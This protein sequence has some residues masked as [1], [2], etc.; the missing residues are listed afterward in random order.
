MAKWLDNL[1]G[2]L[3]YTRAKQAGRRNFAG[4]DVSR[5]TASWNP[6]NISVN[7]DLKTQLPLLRARSR[8]LALN[9]DYAI[10]FLKMVGTHV[11][12]P[13][14]FSLQVHVT[15]P[16]GRPDGLANDAIESA[17]R[18]WAKKGV[19]D[20]TGKLS[21]LDIQQ[22]VAK[23]VARD[24]E[25]LIRKVYG[26]ASGNPHGFGLQ[27]LAIDR[28]DVLR[29]EDALTRD[30][31]VIRMG[32]E[33]TKYGKPIAYHLRVTNPADGVY[34]LNNGAMYERVPADQIY[35]LFVPH[36][37]EQI[38]GIPWMHTAILRLQNL[39]G[40]EEAAV[41][42]A[43]VGASKM[44]F[45]KTDDGD[46]TAMAD[47][48]DAQGNLI[49]EADP[50]VFDVLP[51]GVDFQSFN[52]DYPTANYEPFVKSC[53]RGIA[54]GLGV[55]YNTLSNDL[56]GVNFSSIRTGV[57]EERDNWMVIQ[58]WLIDSWLQDV[59]EQWLRMAMLNDQVVMPNG[60]A[61]P[62]AKFDKFNRAHWAGRRWSWVDPLKDAEA[63][64]LLV[65]NR[66]KSRQDV[67]A[68]AGRDLDDTWRQLRQEQELAAVMGISL[69]SDDTIA[70]SGTNADNS[71]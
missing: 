1:A 31:N 48:Q 36:E 21:W 2:R 67:M 64:I 12:G 42:A 69:P 3:G 23:A 49:K 10:K 65:N 70:S 30:G 24:G 62:I 8:D 5:L 56:E 16:D 57:L 35:H 44:G 26:R 13:T 29:N 47:A 18:K 11:V 27:V 50:G 53:L 17:F 33:M 40:F 46:P 20:V 6:V 66:L 19:C 61:L 52:P 68:E 59:F 63:A 55:A 15:E 34:S 39:G 41:I 43:R 51:P 4:A 60:S 37:P 14:G 7:Q 45:F 71:A 28:L 38:R 9:N 54:S 22:L 25:V 58:N 32:V